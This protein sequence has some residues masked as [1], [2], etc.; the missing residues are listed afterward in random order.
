MNKNEELLPTVT[1][2][3]NALRV[4]AF[5]SALLIPSV[6]DAAQRERPIS[7]YLD[8][9]KIKEFPKIKECAKEANFISNVLHDGKSFEDD[10]SYYFNCDLEFHAA[11]AFF[12][13]EHKNLKVV[14][15]T[16]RVVNGNTVGYF[17]TF[18]KQ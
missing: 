9:D 8:S 11:L 3:K 16:G 6:A 12:Q 17:V 5:A 14:T 7:P 13:N 4:A 18:R 15:M 1:G 2:R 10:G